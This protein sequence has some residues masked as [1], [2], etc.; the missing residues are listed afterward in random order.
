MFGFDIQILDE[1]LLALYKSQI[2]R[3][4]ASYSYFKSDS[5]FDLF[6]PKDFK[7]GPGES[8]MIDFEIRIE[9]RFAGGYYLY[10]RSSISKLPLRLKNSVGIIDNQYRGNLKAAI[11]NTSTTETVELKKGE[12]Y[13]QLCHPTL[14]AMKATIVEKL[15]ET[16]RGA[17]GFGSTGK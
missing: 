16:A 4:N 11:E 6:L 14:I 15:G 3:L 12:R 2:S 9:P 1:E 13:F 5:G 17:G 8:R 7:L 10:P